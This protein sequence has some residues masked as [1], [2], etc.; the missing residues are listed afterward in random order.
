MRERE[1]IPLLS[2]SD[3]VCVFKVASKKYEANQT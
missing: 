3:G 1:R 2:F